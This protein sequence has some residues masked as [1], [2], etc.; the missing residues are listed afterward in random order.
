[1]NECPSLFSRE[2]PGRV[3]CARSLLHITSG[4]DSRVHHVHGFVHADGFVQ[5]RANRVC[6]L[7]C[8]SPNDAMVL[9]CLCAG[10]SFDTGDRQE[11]EHCWGHAPSHYQNS[12]PHSPFALVQMNS[13]ALPRGA[14]KRRV[15]Y[16]LQAGVGTLY[17]PIQFIQF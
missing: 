13:A 6:A 4:K 14:Q 9:L 16:K 2:C 12:F 17:Y 11:S 7:Y 15:A 10:A 8:L 3:L 1:M 5:D